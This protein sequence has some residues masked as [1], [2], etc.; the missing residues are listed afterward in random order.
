MTLSKSTNNLAYS[1][2]N[3]GST[4]VQK[5]NTRPVPAPSTPKLLSAEG[6]NDSRNRLDS[7]FMSELFS[8]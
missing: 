8:D 3:A 2:N 1:V 4:R 6:S 7:D 5:Q